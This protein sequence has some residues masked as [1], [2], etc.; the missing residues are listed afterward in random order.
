[1]LAVSKTFAR[2]VAEIF[3]KDAFTN[4]DVF[5]AIDHDVST[6]THI[7]NVAFFAALLA[8][9][10]GYSAGD[11]EKIAVGGLLHDLGKMDISEGIVCK[12]G[13][14]TDEEFRLIKMHP[15][16]GFRR[17]AQREDILREQLLMVYQHHERFD[18]GG[19]PVGLTGRE[20]HPW[21]RLCAVVDVFE[22][23]TS[24]RPYRMPMKGAKALEIQNR[25]K[26]LAFD[27]EMLR[28]W[29]LIIQNDW[30]D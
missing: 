4:R 8:T 21:S 26:E 9:R 27:P 11:V 15:T 30:I 7:V 10:L 23:L 5:L 14:L 24:H 28:C 19:Y 20:T 1:A 29:E 6:Y 3:F 18:G 13:R 12:P 25:D 16:F 17:L 22:A 2:S